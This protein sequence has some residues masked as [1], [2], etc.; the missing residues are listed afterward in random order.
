MQSIIKP[1]L[2]SVLIF[3]SFNVF[4]LEQC[5]SNKSSNKLIWIA[6]S[7][8]TEKNTCECQVGYSGDADFTSTPNAQN[9]FSGSCVQDINA[10]TNAWTSP[11][12]I[13]GMTIGAG[14]VVGGGAYLGYK[15]YQSASPNRA[16]MNTRWQGSETDYLGDSNISSYELKGSMDLQNLTDRTSLDSNFELQVETLPESSLV[17]SGIEDS[18]PTLKYSTIGK[19]NVLVDS[20]DR[21]LATWDKVGNKWNPARGAERW[22][23][24]EKL[25]YRVVSRGGSDYLNPNTNSFQS[26]LPPEDPWKGSADEY[27]DALGEERT[28]DIEGVGDRLP[29]EAQHVAKNPD[30]EL[31][32][33]ESR[34]YYP[35][36]TRMAFSVDQEDAVL[37]DKNDR[38]LAE[39]D[40]VNKK[41]VPAEGAERWRFS[42]TAGHRVIAKSDTNYYNPNTQKFEE[43]PQDEIKPWEGSSRSYRFSKGIAGRELKGA[44]EPMENLTDDITNDNDVVLQQ[45]SSITFRSQGKYGSDVRMMHN[46]DTGENVLVDK[47][48]RLLSEWK[49]GEWKSA[50]G[51]ERWTYNKKLGYKVI[52]KDEDG[53]VFLNPNEY[54]AEWTKEGAETWS[55]DVAGPSGIDTNAAANTVRSSK[56][57]VFHNQVKTQTESGELE[58][59]PLRDAK[60]GIKKPLKALPEEEELEEIDLQTFSD[61]RAKANHGFE[62]DET[63]L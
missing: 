27:M 1:F 51:A 53:E 36:K 57:I 32:V 14:A 54:K 5:L 40:S 12:A 52:A 34:Q 16:W 41:W 44:G 3:S 35:S 46:S 6:H 28:F 63:C 18:L 49:D 15:F 2:F 60:V 20:D 38:L 59:E 33:S 7:I 10:E 62:E 22:R 37:V 45:E 26:E 29:L 11:L 61:S 8:H 55:E 25:G 4:S 17:N 39:W 13:S 21:L 24:S 43:I 23:F 58:Y 42:Q 9:R 30:F 48:N 56:K 50:D 31:Q 19:V 47:E